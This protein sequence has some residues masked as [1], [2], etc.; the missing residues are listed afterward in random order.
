[1][2]M[3]G[4]FQV[5]VLIQQEQ[6]PRAA[7]IAAVQS[8]QVVS[9]GR[10]HHSRLIEKLQPWWSGLNA[11]AGSPQNRHRDPWTTLA[12]IHP[13]VLAVAACVPSSLAVRGTAT[14]DSSFDDRAGRPDAPWRAYRPH[15][16][17][18]HAVEDRAGPVCCRHGQHPLSLL[19]CCKS[20]L[21]A[22]CKVDREVQLGITM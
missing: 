20:Q 15:S 11:P 16:G 2:Q 7:R 3:I 6:R 21:P 19:V 12:S 5:T 13:V 22:G 1:M 18:L 10:H 17:S 9:Q 8:T 14:M 4:N